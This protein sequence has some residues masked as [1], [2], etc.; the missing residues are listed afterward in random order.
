MTRIALV[1][2]LNT[3]PF[4]DGLEAEF[5]AGEISLDVLPPAECAAAM[6]AG[7][8]EMA[9]LPVGSL[10]DF[11]GL[12]VMNDF[13]IGAEGAV[14]SVFLFS[15]VPAQDVTELVLDP[16]SR[17]SNMLARILFQE[18]WHANPR[19]ATRNGRSLE[20][21]EGS[22]AAV[23]IG[24]LAYAQREN[25]PYVYDLSAEWKAL[26]G[27]PFV[28]AVWVYR[29]GTIDLA[30]MARIQTALKSGFENRASSA[31][32]WG[33]FYGYSQESAMDYLCQSI[34]Y[35]FTMDKHEAM[36]RYFGALSMMMSNVMVVDGVKH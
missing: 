25:Y 5:S 31:L 19:L 35:P 26:T 8:C 28:F 9:L 2:Y 3:R 21:V 36:E 33:E 30:T 4:M 17:T 29:P 23:L 18:L 12:E 7:T 27:L 10:T 11:Q 13:C 24:D 34:D 15:Q 22:T 16:H 32:K 20:V 6:A 1:S 14:N